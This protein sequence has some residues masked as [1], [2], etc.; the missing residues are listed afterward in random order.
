MGIYKDFVIFLLGFAVIIK[1]A[2]FFTDGAEGIAR[3]FHIPRLIIGLT[4]VSLATTFPEFTVSSISSYM[5]SSGMAIGNA[6]GSCICNMALILAV[7]ALIN[8]LRLKSRSVKPEIIFFISGALILYLFI[9]DGRL[10][11]WEGLL[12]ILL[13]AAFF[14]F[15]VR[16]ELKA[17][18]GSN[19]ERS[20]DV[21]IKLS[22]VKFCI[23]TAG[24]ILAAKYAII[25]SGI[26][27]AHFLGVPEIVIGLSMVA[28]GTSLPELA[29]AGV[30]SFKKMGEL[31]VGNV[32][33]ANILNILWVLGGASMIRSLN[34]DFQT[35]SFTMPVVLL[36]GALVLLFAGSGFRLTRAEGSV[37]LLIYTGY[38]FYI[39]KFAY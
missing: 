9:L 17:R 11:R 39:Y 27:I 30:A 14:V 36:I 1:S 22:L 21:N 26:K 38:I 6:L 25:P 29:A 5:G 13:L 4:I 28:L 7:A 37:L 15:I 35:L 12:L 3:A 10:V 8:P 32:I 16:R 2:D 34:V 23:G 33:G 24:V 18:K 19:Q 20:K 31:A